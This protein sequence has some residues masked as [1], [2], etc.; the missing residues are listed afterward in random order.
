MPG[1]SGT[2]N[3]DDGALAFTLSSA[4]GGIFAHN[5]ATGPA[6]GGKGVLGFFACLPERLTPGSRRH[7]GLE[8]RS[9]FQPFPSQH[10]L[11]QQKALRTRGKDGSSGKP[12][13]KNVGARSWRQQALLEAYFTLNGCWFSGSRR[14]QKIVKWV[15][16]HSG[17]DSRSWIEPFCGGMQNTPG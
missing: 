13:K 9:G 4:K 5:D 14:V 16:G 6:P 17:I 11:W 2:S 15:A 8:F 12:S 3:S 10:L 1:S 7:S